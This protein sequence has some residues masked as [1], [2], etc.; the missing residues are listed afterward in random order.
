MVAAVA[1]RQQ[2]VVVVAFEPA[3]VQFSVPL[4]EQAA[5]VALRRAASNHN[6]FFDP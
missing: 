6:F 3:A 4:R 1:E 5:G 2:K